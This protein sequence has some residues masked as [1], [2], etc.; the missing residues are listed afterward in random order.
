MG[1]VYAQNTQNSQN[2]KWVGI[3]MSDGCLLNGSCTSDPLVAIWIREEVSAEW[4]TA[5]SIVQDM[6]LWATFFIGTI[7]TI[8]LIRSGFLMMTAGAEEG[9][10]EQG[11]KWIIASIIWLSLV[12]LS[13]VIIRLIQFIAQW[14]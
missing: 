10:F 5:K 1:Q 12:S 9:K 13:Y 6:F 11:K 2:A 8:A 4:N 7:C 14:N 3:G